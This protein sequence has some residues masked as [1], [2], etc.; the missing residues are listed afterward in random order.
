MSDALVLLPHL[1]SGSRRYSTAGND[2]PRPVF[3]RMP[4]L[5]G[6][7]GASHAALVLATNLLTPLNKAKRRTTDQQRLTDTVGAIHKSP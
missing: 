6:L 1:L 3:L 2:V 4:Q 5:P 7:L